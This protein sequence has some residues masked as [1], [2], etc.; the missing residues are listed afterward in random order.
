M[1]T[2]TS[3]GLIELIFI[4]SLPIVSVTNQ[5]FNFYMSDRQK[6]PLS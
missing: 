4:T 6:V 2:H 5:S 3:N 1:Y